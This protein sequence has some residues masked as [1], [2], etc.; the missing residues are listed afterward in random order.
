MSNDRRFITPEE[1]I[2]LLNDGDTIHT[3]RNSPGMLMGADHSRKSILKTINDNPDKIEIGG[4]GCRSMNHGLVVND[5]GPLFIET[6]EEKLNA[7]DPIN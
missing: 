5:D 2:S 6:N 1:A 3:F 7:F 4:E